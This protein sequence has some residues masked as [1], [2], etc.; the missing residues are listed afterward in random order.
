VACGVTDVG[1][2]GGWHASLGG[3]GNFIFENLGS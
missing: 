2:E 1:G 3:G